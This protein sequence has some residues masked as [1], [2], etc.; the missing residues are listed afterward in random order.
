MIGRNQG[1]GCN[2]LLICFNFCN[3]RS[4]KDEAS[5]DLASSAGDLAAVRRAGIFGA[6]ASGKSNVNSALLFMRR[7]VV[8]SFSTWAPDSGVPR[9]GYALRERPK[10][11]SSRFEVE[12]LV[13]DVAY[14]YGFE[15]DD[16]RVLSEWL[17]SAP[18]G[19]RRVIFERDVEG[20][21]FGRSAGLERGQ[22][23]ALRTVRAN[24]LLLSYA[25]QLEAESLRPVSTW[26]WG[27]HE[28]SRRDRRERLLFAAQLIEQDGAIGRTMRRLVAQA[29]LGITGV[30]IERESRPLKA[31]D[32]DDDA[33]IEHFRMADGEIE[34]DAL[35]LRFK[36]ISSDHPDGVLF[37][38]R[39]ES[40]GTQSWLSMLGPLLFVLQEGAL[41]LV[42]EFDAHLHPMLAALML[43]VFASEEANPRGA[44]II[45]NSHNPLLLSRDLELDEERVLRRDEVFFAQKEDGASSLYSLTDFK[46]RKADN[47]LKR[48]LSGRF[49]AIPRPEAE[50]GA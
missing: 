5:L 45:F 32:R 46:P 29:D 38:L 28:I 10:E 16:L 47:I 26:F 37:D 49:G 40:T 27:I 8:H 21:K 50:H 15:V 44:Q 36:H 43:R 7:A 22:A 1:Q 3:W 30:E 42:D 19:R 17:Y 14:T 41:V 39:R 9:D 13:A 4:F 11:T 6:N 33:V 20:I 25:H 31:S 34:V 12:I 18:T 23:S 2:Q 48:Y 35:D 24:A